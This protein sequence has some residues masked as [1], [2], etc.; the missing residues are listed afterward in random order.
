MAELHDLTALDL[1]A[2]LQRGDTTP[3]EVADHALERA[4]QCDPDIGAFVTVTADAARQRARELERSADRTALLWGLPLADKDLVN[5][6]GV[7]TGFGSR[8]FQG[9][10]A[11][12]S[13]ELVKVLDAAGAISIGKTATPEFG[14]AGY[15]EPLATGPVRNPWDRTRGV[16]GS[17]GGAAAAVAARILPF[18]PG[19]DGGGSIRIPAAACGLVGIKPSRGLIPSAS[20]VTSL[21]GLSVGGALARTVADSALLVDAMI[22]RENGRIPHHYALRA[23]DGNDGDLLGAAVRGEGR[24]QL[25]ILTNTPFDDELDIV[26]DPAATAAVSEAANRYTNMGHGIEEFTLEHDGRYGERFRA[27]W[28]ASAASLP[29]DG[30]QLTKLEPLTRHLVE[31]GRGISARQLIETLGALTEFERSVIEQFFRFDAVMTPTLALTPR[32]LGWF[33]AH[34]PEH[35]FRQQC[36]YEPFTSFVNVAGLPA[37]T[38]PVGETPDGLPMGV[39]LI[40][41]PGG[42][43]TLFALG[44]Q[45]ERSIRWQYRAPA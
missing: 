29:V 23:P 16:G 41:R 21:G 30:A 4:A 14:L 18:A 15:T 13:D 9:S 19:S 37:I 28:H 6:E 12:A 17:S 36:E 39:Q 5:R 7:P 33:D 43:A 20:G 42:E 2:A 25:G 8:L 31:R 22:G 34:D 26:I 1:W 32:P 40:G 44:A 10:V 38:L 11:P 45:L 35:N 3:M 24:F 27:L